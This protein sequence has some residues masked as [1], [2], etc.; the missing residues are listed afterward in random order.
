MFRTVTRT[1]A[2]PGLAPPESVAVPVIVIRQG[3]CGE[4]QSN[5]PVVELTGKWNTCRYTGEVMVV[6]GGLP[7]AATSTEC[8][9]G[10]GSCWP[11]PSTALAWITN[12]PPSTGAAKLDVQLLL[13]AP[14]LD[15]EA[16]VSWWVL[17]QVLVAAFHHWPVFLFLT[18]TFTADTLVLSVAVPEMAIVVL[19]GTVAPSAGDVMV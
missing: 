6:S 1:C 17:L 13:A 4:S 10:V 11:P 5:R 9:S 15:R 18:A 8:A 12:V 3:G 14:G 7:F 16:A 19:F 2:T